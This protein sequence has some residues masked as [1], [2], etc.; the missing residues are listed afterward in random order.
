[1]SVDE[2]ARFHER[3]GQIDALPEVGNR[4]W[5][6]GGL[7]LV[8]VVGVLLVPWA[9]QLE[10]PLRRTLIVGGVIFLLGA[11][12][13]ENLSW[14]WERPRGKDAV[15]W[16][17]E[18]IEENLEFLGVLYVVQGLLAHIRRQGPL[19]FTVT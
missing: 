8:A 10:R 17:L 5:L 3:L 16:W 6:G 19:T 2:V 13:L 15:Y 11:V 12:G 18:S 9:L 4:A 1:M 7:V 14:G